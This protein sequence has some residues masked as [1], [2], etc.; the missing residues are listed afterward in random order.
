M[1]EQHVI[2]KIHNWKTVASV[3]SPYQAPETIGLCL[4]GDV[5]GH[6]GFRDGDSVRTSRVVEIK[7]RI[8]YTVSGSVYKLGRID[9]K[10]RK[11]LRK[12]RPNWNWR[13]PITIKN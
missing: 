2:K 12:H 10:F 3:G 5:Y 6:E 13:N 9:P 11:F 8:V 4:K 1:I 7:G